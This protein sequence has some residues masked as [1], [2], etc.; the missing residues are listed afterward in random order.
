MN[1]KQWWTLSIAFAFITFIGYLSFDATRLYQSTVYSVNNMIEKV[2][3]IEA[4]NASSSDS[5]R[6]ILER[7]IY[8]LENTMVTGSTLPYFYLTI[9]SAIFS[10]AFFFIG[11]FER[12]DKKRT[13]TRLSPPA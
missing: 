7:A 2:E 6:I 11:F 3:K 13:V 9:V 10:I 8:S 12:E 5:N 1:K 4:V